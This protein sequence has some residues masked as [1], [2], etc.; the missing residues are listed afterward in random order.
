MKKTKNTFG[1]PYF[2]KGP[3]K[4]IARLNLMIDALDAVRVQRSVDIDSA[5]GPGGTL[6]T[7]RNPQGA[8]G[9][10]FIEPKTFFVSSAD[11]ETETRIAVTSGAINS[12]IYDGTDG[13]YN[14]SNGFKVWLEVDWDADGATVLLID[15][16]VGAS[17]PANDSITSYTLLATVAVAAG[18]TTVTPLAWNYSQAQACG[19]DGD[20]NMIVNYW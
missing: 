11:T 13:P 9:R 14:V 16:G 5:V 19:A 18:A 10:G 7:I 1:I 2:T 4:L 3:P 20:G 12:E 6:L 15:V 8:T 17:M